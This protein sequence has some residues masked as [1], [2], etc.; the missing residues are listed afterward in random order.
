M[1][2]LPTSAYT[3]K[4]TRYTCILLACLWLPACAVTDSVVS[5]YTADEPARAL[6]LTHVGDV[7]WSFFWGL[8]KQEDWAAGCQSGSDM[9]QVRVRTNPLF[10]TVSF[11]S[12]GLAVPQRLEWDC[13]PPP[14]EPGTIGTDN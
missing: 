13:A 3:R 9:S 6:H 7:H 5:R 1:M 11:L 8:L 2:L 4:A 12:L 10:I 14:R